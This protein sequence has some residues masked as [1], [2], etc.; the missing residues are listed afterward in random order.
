MRLFRRAAPT[1]VRHVALMADGRGATFFLYQTRDRG[2]RWSWNFD[3]TVPSSQPDL[4]GHLVMMAQLAI[5]RM[6]AMLGIPRTA[7]PWASS[8][9]NFD[10]PGWPWT[11][12]L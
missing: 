7:A 4:T 5:R 8:E 10:L 9:P 11:T 3:P 12:D 2:H 1:M 6:E